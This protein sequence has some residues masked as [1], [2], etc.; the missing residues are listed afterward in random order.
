MTDGHNERSLGQLTWLPRAAALGVGTLLPIVL[1]TL[2]LQGAIT[3]FVGCLIVLLLAMWAFTAGDRW[4]VLLPVAVSLGGVFFWGKRVHAYEIALVLCAA[5]LIPILA[6]RKRIPQT[7]S[8]LPISAFMLA[9]YLIAHAIFSLYITKT[10]GSGNLGTVMRVYVRGLWAILFAI[11]F[12]TVGTTRHARIALILMYVAAILSVSLGFLGFLNPRLLYI[13]VINYVPPGIT[14]AGIELRH[15]AIVLV[16]MAIAMASFAAK[17]RWRLLHYLIAILASICVFLGGS[18][19]SFAILLMIPIFWAIIK[20]NYIALVVS[21][22]AILIALV[23]INLA[24]DVLLG[25]LPRNVQRTLSGALIT[26]SDHAER[27]HAGGSYKWHF[28]LMSRA[29]RKWTTNA[30]TLLLGNRVQALAS[31]ENTERASFYQKMEIS[32]GLGYYESGLWTVLATLGLVGLALYAAFFIWLLRDL[33]TPLLRHGICD[34]NHAFYFLAACTSTIWVLF[35]WGIGHFPSYELML[36]II[37][38]ALFE[39]HRQQHAH[40]T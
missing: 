27:F 31:T 12:Y 25:N 32:E 2:Y 23:A 10:S 30:G 17:R 11:T 26:S 19:G 22:T 28:E 37:A 29:K 5:P 36:A 15:S 4:W 38:K 39:D 3:P 1:L 18:R 9:G 20:K 6:V 7:R 40:H 14:T 33:F 34:I 21:G 35:C 13:P 24:P 8:P 16:P